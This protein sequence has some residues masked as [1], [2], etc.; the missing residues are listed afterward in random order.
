MSPPHRTHP[1]RAA[2]L[3][4]RPAFDAPEVPAVPASDA[5]EDL[6]ARIAACTHCA[7]H[8]PLGPRPVVQFTATSSIVIVSQAPGRRVHQSGIPFDDPSGD[9]LRGW[10]G[11]DRPAFYD[12]SRI[13]VVPVGFCYPGT[14]PSGD[15]PPRPE[16]APLWHHAV[17]AQLPE[18]RL[19][20][21][22]GAHAQRLVLGRDFRGSLTATVEAW[23]DLV[24]RYLPLP[25]PSPR[26]QAWFKRHPWFEAELVPRLR[27]AVAAGRWLED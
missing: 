17:F 3:V 10:L 23:R 12:P 14:G 11:L 4:V 9:R 5:I 6:R 19:T 20:L 26:N 13:A 8:L 18:Q 25:H 15:L 22:V 16:C 27:S 1:A 21:L 24:P 7:E 2:T